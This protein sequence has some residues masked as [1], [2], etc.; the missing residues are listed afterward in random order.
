MCGSASHNTFGPNFG[1]CI[2]RDTSTTS[3]LH[4]EKLMYLDVIGTTLEDT[5]DVLLHQ[6]LTAFDVLM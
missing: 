2:A 6:L 3:L 1:R 5:L 4:Q